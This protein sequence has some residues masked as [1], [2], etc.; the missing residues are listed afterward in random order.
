MGIFIFRVTLSC[1]LTFISNHKW[2]QSSKWE[3]NRHSKAKCNVYFN[4]KFMSI[5]YNWRL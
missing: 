5:T 4:F 2:L 1:S 3:W